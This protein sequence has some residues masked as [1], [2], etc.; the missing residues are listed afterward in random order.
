MYVTI[1]HMGKHKR[2]FY[3]SSQ[4]TVTV[5]TVDAEVAA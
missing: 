5:T 3:N 4:L 1:F 2:H